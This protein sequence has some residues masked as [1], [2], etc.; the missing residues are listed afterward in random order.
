LTAPRKGPAPAGYLE[1]EKAL[2]LLEAADVPDVLVAQRLE[3][4]AHP[5]GE[6]AA[7]LLRNGRWRAAVLQLERALERMAGP[8][9]ARNLAWFKADTVEP[10]RDV[11]RRLW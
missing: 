4:L 1:I 9:D 2:R 3:R 6:R 8:E 11:R 5:V 7:S 10:A